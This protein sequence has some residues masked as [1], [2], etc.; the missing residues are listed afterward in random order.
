MGRHKQIDYYFE[1]TK[2]IP[3]QVW[4]CLHCDIPAEECSGECTGGKVKR[5]KYMVWDQQIAY[6]MWLEGCTDREIAC[7]VGRAESTIA[8][9]RKKNKLFRADPAGN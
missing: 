3:E 9:W 1:L 5:K 6:E 2:D 4:A 8:Y 7:C